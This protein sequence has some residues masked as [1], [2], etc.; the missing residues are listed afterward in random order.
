MKIQKIYNNNIA[1]VLND[2]GE[3]AIVSGRGIAFG[4]K[5][6]GFI[7]SSKIDKIFEVRSDNKDYVDE[8]ISEIPDDVMMVCQHIL[9]KAE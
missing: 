7:D 3:E 9:E 1:S 5:N 2:T 8:L 4:K 6:G